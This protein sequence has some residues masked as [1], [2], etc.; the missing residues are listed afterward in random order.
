MREEKEEIQTEKKVCG[1]RVVNTTEFIN[2]E[3]CQ[4]R[5]L[6]ERHLEA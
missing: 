5:T 4:E 1:H 2:L 3:F 6:V